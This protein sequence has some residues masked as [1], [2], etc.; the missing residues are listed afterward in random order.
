MNT[1]LQRRRLLWQLYEFALR[2]AAGET[3]TDQWGY[4]IITDGGA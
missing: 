1:L 2:D 4:V 3:I